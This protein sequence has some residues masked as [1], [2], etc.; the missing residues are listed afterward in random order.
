MQVFTVVIVGAMAAFLWWLS[1]LRAKKIQQFTDPYAEAFCKAA[2]HVLGTSPINASLNYEKVEG[3]Q[4]HV[5]PVEDQPEII[6]EIVRRG[7]DAY[8]LSQIND[9]YL[10][11]DKAQELLTTVNLIGKRYN[12]VMNHTYSLT[13]LFF[14]VLADIT[15]IKS[16]KDLD[17]FHSYLQKQEYLRTS[18]LASI[19]SEACQKRIASREYA[20]DENK[21]AV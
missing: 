1:T 20:S 2:D 3:G 13:N 18:A 9:M 10:Y 11:R 6:Q 8:A 4:I 21:I 5:R 17:D 15:M 19:T 12:M 7:V 14:T 16:E